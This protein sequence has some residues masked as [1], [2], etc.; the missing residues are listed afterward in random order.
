[1]S[2]IQVSLASYA[3]SDRSTIILTRVRPQPGKKANDLIIDF[4]SCM[5]E[6]A[7]E[8]ITREIGTVADL[9]M[10]STSNNSSSGR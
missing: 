4:L 9:G 7:K 8:Q 2:P 3:A 6:Y 10:F 5:W 1:M